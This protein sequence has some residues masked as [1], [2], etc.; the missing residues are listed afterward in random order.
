VGTSHEINDALC[1]HT[2]S[3]WEYVEHD[4]LM[5]ALRKLIIESV[6]EKYI[7]NLRNKY[8]HYNAIT[9][10]AILKHLFNNYGKITSEDIV[11]NKNRL[12]EPWDGADHF[13]NIIDHINKC[14]EFA[15]E[16]KRPYTPEQILDQA[17]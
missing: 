1:A 15:K 8:T 11:Q 9:P 6:E 2:D 14:V 17:H 3:H 12:T 7:K 10:S 13:K 5:Q 16:A 4:V